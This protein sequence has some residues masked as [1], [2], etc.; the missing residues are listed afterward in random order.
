MAFPPPTRQQRQATDTQFRVSHS[1]T[2]LL[3][4]RAWYCALLCVWLANRVRLD[5]EIERTWEVIRVSWWFKHD[6]FEPVLATLSFGLWI[7]AWRIVDILCP[8]LHRWRIDPN[9]LKPVNQGLLEFIL[10]PG[11]GYCAAVAYLLPL[12]I[13]DQLYP[14]RVVPER[15]ARCAPTTA[16]CECTA[17][18]LHA[19][20][21]L[22]KCRCS[23]THV[24]EQ[25][26]GASVQCCSVCRCVR[27][28]LL[29]GASSA[30]QRPMATP[31]YPCNAPPAGT[32]DCSGGGTPFFGRRC[33]AGR[34]QH[35]CL[36]AAWTAPDGARCSQRR[37]HVLADGVACG[38]RHAMD[39]AQCCAVRD[40]GRPT[41]PRGTPQVCNGA[42]PPG[43]FLSAY[44]LSCD[45]RDGMW[46]HTRWVACQ[47]FTYMDN[48]LGYDKLASATANRCKST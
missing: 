11:I 40:I 26:S 28:H 36:E 4:W 39:A 34:G 29:L 43:T 17:S 15:S 8:S 47:F 42:F 31:Q 22:I 5:Y 16:C 7:L 25:L 13:F 6:S 10:R 45:S 38:L 19:A 14:R 3:L 18:P 20:I 41:T 2:A 12:L 9:P 46:S 1:R 37:R 33:S 48:W 35:S 27:F 23:L 21:H 24:G 32:A 44:L 30:A